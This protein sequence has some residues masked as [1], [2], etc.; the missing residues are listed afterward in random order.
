MP[1]FEFKTQDERRN[2][3]CPYNLKINDVA[4]NTSDNE[5]VTVGSSRCYHCSYCDKDNSTPDGLSLTCLH[6]EP[7]QI[8]PEDIS[9]AI[10]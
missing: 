2:T 6:N 1:V 5:L 8:L 10:F 9:I 7:P 4:Q 3:K